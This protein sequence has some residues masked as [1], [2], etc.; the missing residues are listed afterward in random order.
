MSDDGRKVLIQSNGTP[1]GTFVY[2]MTGRAIKGL[3]T[4]IEWSINP[5]RLATAVITFADVELKA[6][7]EEIPDPLDQ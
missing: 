6:P 3:I 2:D 5:D 1:S 7:A 4:K